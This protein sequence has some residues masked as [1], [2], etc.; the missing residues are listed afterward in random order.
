MVET[1]RSQR[2][3]ILRAGKIVVA[4][5]T[6]RAIIRDVSENGAL[7]QCDMELH[8]GEHVELHIK[9]EPS[10]ICEVRWIEGDRVGLQY[11]RRIGRGEAMTADRSEATPQSFVV[12]N[13]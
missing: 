7:I 6:R 4:G 9:D 8:L 5:V 2:A 1:D 12:V 10:M 3:R 11:A 13:G